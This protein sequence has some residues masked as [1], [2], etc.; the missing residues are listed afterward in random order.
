[1]NTQTTHIQKMIIL[2]AG[3]GALNITLKSDQGH[4]NNWVEVIMIQSLNHLTS[5][6]LVYDFAEL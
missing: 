6:V 5:A 3:G 4:Q 1:M 2:G